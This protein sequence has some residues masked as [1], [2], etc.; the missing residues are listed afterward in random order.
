M[1]DNKQQYDIFISY[2]RDIRGF[3][4]CL[5]S[6]LEKLNFGTVFLDVDDIS[7][8]EKWFEK[9]ISAL[10]SARIGIICYTKSNRECRPWLHLE[11]GVIAYKFYHQTE[12][13]SGN[14]MLL[15][16]IFI[17]FDREDFG[18]Y[19]FSG[20]N[21]CSFNDDDIKFRVIDMLYSIN[22]SKKM[23]YGSRVEIEEELEKFPK[24]LNSLMEEI[25]KI[26]N[27]TDGVTPSSND[28]VINSKRTLLTVK[29]GGSYAPAS[30]KMLSAIYHMFSDDNRGKFDVTCSFDEAIHF[31]VEKGNEKNFIIRCLLIFNHKV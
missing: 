26:K 10:D 16:P 13:E 5:K 28:N 7:G 6:V 1:P 17:D 8:G 15:L 30:I 12:S 25:S 29:S 27:N 23:K 19:P 21:G 18:K 20:I 24:E 4:I 11:A 3:A 2:S 9:I 31:L 14:K 22:E